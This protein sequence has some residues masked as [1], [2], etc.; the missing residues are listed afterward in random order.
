[1][2]EIIMLVT[3]LLSF[4]SLEQCVY[5]EDKPMGEAK[6]CSIQKGEIC[7]EWRYVIDRY[8][9]YED[10]DCTPFEKANDSM[11]AL[12]SQEY[13]CWV[14]LCG[15]LIDGEGYYSNWGMEGTPS[16]DAQRKVRNLVIK[17]KFRKAR[18]AA[19]KALAHLIKVNDCEKD[20]PCDDMLEFVINA[21]LKELRM[22]AKEW[23]EDEDIREEDSDPLIPKPRQP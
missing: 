14:P 8:C 10:N 1:M 12:R 6:S 20:E 3:S 23:R 11:N 21:S 19:R 9:A 4:N 16:A 15:W 7:F 5:A 2:I 13:W 18:A 17:K 22:A